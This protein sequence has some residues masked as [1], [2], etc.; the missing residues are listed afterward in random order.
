MKQ[1][2]LRGPAYPSPPKSA[3]IDLGMVVKSPGFGVLTDPQLETLFYKTAGG[4]PCRTVGRLTYK[5]PG[6]QQVIN[7]D[8]ICMVSGSCWDLVNVNDE[9]CME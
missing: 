1:R 4:P 5:M 2:F 7:S 3:K 6:T 9:P 8:V